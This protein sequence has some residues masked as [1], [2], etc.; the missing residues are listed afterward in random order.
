MHHHTL[1]ILRWSKPHH[2]VQY[3]SGIPALDGSRDQRRTHQIRTGREFV[4]RRRD[5]QPRLCVRLNTSIATVSSPMTAEELYT[6]L[7][8]FTLGVRWGLDSAKNNKRRTK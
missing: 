2:G 6:W 5:G 7:R 3:L 8:A 4:I 1:T